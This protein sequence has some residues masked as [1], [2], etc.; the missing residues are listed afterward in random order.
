MQNELLNISIGADTLRAICDNPSAYPEE[1][2]SAA[3]VVVKDM[4]SQIREAR[5]HL[6]GVLI[7]KMKT[8]NATKLKFIGVDGRDYTATMKAGSMECDDKSADVTYQNEGFDPLEIG[9]YVF[10]P[11]WSKAKEVR[12]LGGNKQLLIDEFFKP[13]KPSV[14]IKEA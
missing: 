2:I 7:E 5:T 13:G 9:S 4:A 3:I 8:E 14:D 12:K 1:M 11:S 6:E 10:K